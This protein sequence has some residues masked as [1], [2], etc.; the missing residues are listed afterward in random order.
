V[1]EHSLRFR[2]IHLDFHTSEQIAGVASEFDAETFADTLRARES[3]SAVLRGSYVKGFGV[4]RQTGWCERRAVEIGGLG[5]AVGARIAERWR[6]LAPEFDER[7]RRL[8]AAAEA[9]SHGPGGVGAVVRAT[10][11][12]EDTVRRGLAE[13][14]S[15]ER[16]EPGRCGVRAGA[17]SR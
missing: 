12:S 6:L 14:E 11:I 1:D 5:G 7:R 13:L 8:W 10:G 3:S 16:V 9:R 2:Q 15:G 17:A 4:G